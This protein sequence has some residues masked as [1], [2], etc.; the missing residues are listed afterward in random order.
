MLLSWRSFV[1]TVTFRG[2]IL[3]RLYC[4]LRNV[5]FYFVTKYELFGPKCHKVS[6]SCYRVYSKKTCDSYKSLCIFT[7]KKCWRQEGLDLMLQGGKTKNASVMFLLWK[8]ARKWHDQFK[9]DH[10]DT[11]VKRISVGSCP[12]TGFGIS[13]AEPLASATTTLELFRSV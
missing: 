11:G 7:V 8:S 12:M 2:E 4:W 5:A 6:N 1:R 9:M 10:W 13:I 3:R